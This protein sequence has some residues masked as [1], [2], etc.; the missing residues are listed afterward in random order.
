MSAK[1]NITDARSR[2]LQ[3]R[4]RAAKRAARRQQA[5]TET[6]SSGLRHIVRWPELEAMTR[7]G[8][9]AIQ[10]DIIEGRFPKPIPLGGRAIG[11]LVKEVEEWIAQRAIAR[12]QHI[13]AAE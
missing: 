4:K 12:N 13:E 3:A 8:R 6:A 9:T 2:E 7:R 5:L 10:Q 1:K 11:W